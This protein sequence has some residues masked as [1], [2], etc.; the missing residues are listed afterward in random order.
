MA[1]TKTLV[2]WTA[3]DI[4]TIIRAWPEHHEL[5]VMALLGNRYTLDAVRSKAG[6]LGLTKTPAYRQ[7]SRTSLR[8]PA[9]AHWTCPSCG[10][11]CSAPPPPSC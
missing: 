7:L 9:R 8:M 10:S 3:A 4:V 11:S 5:E 2:R 6:Y 1:R